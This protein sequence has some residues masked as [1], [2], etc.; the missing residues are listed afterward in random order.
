MTKW[1]LHYFVPRSGKRCCLCDGKAF[2]LHS[3]GFM[4]SSNRYG[5]RRVRDEVSHGARSIVRRGR[6]FS[7]RSTLLR[8]L[9]RLCCQ[10]KCHQLGG[11]GKRGSVQL[12]VIRGGERVVKMYL[13]WKDCIDL[14]MCYRNASCPP[15]CSRQAKGPCVSGGPTADDAVLEEFRTSGPTLKFCP[16][17][18]TVSATRRDAVSAT[19]STVLTNRT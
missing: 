17:A 19:R 16:L 7:R 8:P 3:Y 9:R 18:Y 2:R 12:G 1:P 6:V 13:L 15:Q 5:P 4:K 14:P 10:R 11:R